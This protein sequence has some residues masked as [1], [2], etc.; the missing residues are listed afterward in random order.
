[1][2][3]W[4]FIYWRTCCRLSE[5]SVTGNLYFIFTP[6]T[7][8]ANT[9]QQSPGALLPHPFFPWSPSHFIFRER[10]K[11]EVWCSRDLSPLCLASELWLIPLLWGVLDRSS[12]PSVET[13]SFSSY[14]GLHNEDFGKCQRYAVSANLS[15][16]LLF[17]A[18]I[19]I[20][21]FWNLCIFLPGYLS[22]SPSL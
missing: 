22:L 8:K 20:F 9:S 6:N 7:W 16:L 10:T 17:W 11:A 4:F 12:P 13:V 3:C 14:P 15:D 5:P 18:T 1:M 19:I 2:R 21:S